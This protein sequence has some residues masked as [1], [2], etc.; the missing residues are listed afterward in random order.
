MIQLALVCKCPRYTTQNMSYC[1]NNVDKRSRFQLQKCSCKTIKNKRKHAM[2]NKV[3]VMRKYHVCTSHLLNIFR[4]ETIINL[5][6]K[7]Y[8]ANQCSIYKHVIVYMSVCKFVTHLSA[9]QR[10]NVIIQQT[11]LVWRPK[12]RYLTADNDG[13]VFTSSSV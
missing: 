11:R 4:N 8:N 3:T 1:D 10:H 13:T 6:R 2:I 12:S 5:Y 7:K 9:S